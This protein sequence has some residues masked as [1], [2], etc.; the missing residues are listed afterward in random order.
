MTIEDKSKEKALINQEQTYF[1]VLLSEY[2]KPHNLQE[3]C[4]KKD[5][6]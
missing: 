6:E 2:G 1:S 4:H 5:P 3:S